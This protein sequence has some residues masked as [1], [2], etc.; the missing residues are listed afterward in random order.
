MSNTGF[1]VDLRP[2][3]RLVKESYGNR[4]VYRVEEDLLPVRNNYLAGV[5]FVL[6]LSFFLLWGASEKG[7]EAQTPAKIEKAERQYP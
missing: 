7:N 4:E 1:N 3:L 5:M 6:I 2:G